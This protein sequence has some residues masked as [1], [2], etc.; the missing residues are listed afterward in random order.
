MDKTSMKS[1][2]VGV[3]EMRSVDG[4]NC[5]TSG[6]E[7]V[8]QQ[9]R[10]RYTSPSL[11]S[12][13]RVKDLVKN[14]THNGAENAQQPTHTMAPSD[15]RT[16]DKIVQFGE[17]DCGIGR[18]IYKYKTEY[19]ADNSWFMGVMADEVERAYPEAVVTG[20]NGYSMV[21]Y[22]ILA[23]VLSAGHP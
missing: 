3:A 23:R 2:E 17:Y 13:G 21:D 1:S 19:A 6:D 12:F 5:S 10:K 22:S 7:S 15:R 11:T 9:K 8:S 20:G 16:K 4:R 18:Y 14:G